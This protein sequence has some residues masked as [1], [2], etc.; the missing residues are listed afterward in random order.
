M[1]IEILTFFTLVSVNILVDAKIYKRSEL[2]TELVTKHK[3]NDEHAAKIS[4]IAE[5]ALFE[6][7]RI[8]Y[9]SKYYSYTIFGP[10]LINPEINYGIFQISS[11]HWCDEIGDGGICNLNCRNLVDDDITDDIECLKKIMP[12]FDEEKWYEPW[13]SFFVDECDWK[14]ILQSCTLSRNEEETAWMSL[15]DCLSLKIVYPPYIFVYGGKPAY[16]HE[17]PHVAALGWTQPESNDVTWACGGSLISEDTVLT[18]AHCTFNRENQAPDVVRL[19]DLNLETDDDDKDTQQLEILSIIR[20]PEYVSRYNDIA[21]IKLKKKVFVTHFVIPACLWTSDTIP[22]DINLEASGFGQ[23]EFMGDISAILNKVNVTTISTDACQEYY[24]G[25]RLLRKHG[26]LERVHLCANDKTGNN[27][28]TCGGDSGG[29]LEMKLRVVQEVVPF[30]VG[31]TSFGK[32]CGFDSP[33]VYTRVSSYIDWIKQHVPRLQVDPLECAQSYSLFRYF[34]LA[35]QQ[36]QFE[37]SQMVIFY[38]KGIS[39]S[40]LT[41]LFI[42]KHFIYIYSLVI[43]FRLSHLYS[44]IL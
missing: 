14:S 28:D 26:L 6:T 34:V 40:S 44:L 39:V 11:N 5:G 31:V 42:Y 3:F 35:V 25:D 12:S 20:H 10:E 15:D 13:Y 37:S 4:C 21:L 16:R 38:N 32:G 27:M 7:D 22:Q 41:S 9:H 23:T 2:I 43:Y 17:F 18:A 30:I 24:Q 36:N 33:G 1:I 19:G 29:P 8:G